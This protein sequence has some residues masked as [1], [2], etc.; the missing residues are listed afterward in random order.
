[1]GSAIG[2]NGSASNNNSSGGTGA[3]T[4]T[5]N[6][7]F[8]GGSGATLPA[9]SVGVVAELETILQLQQHNNQQSPQ[10]TATKPG[11]MIHHHGHLH[12]PQ[13]LRQHVARSSSTGN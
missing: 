4:N 7:T 2:S 12:T 6:S 1:M 3:G 9:A 10:T 5:A 11:H 13:P 8:S